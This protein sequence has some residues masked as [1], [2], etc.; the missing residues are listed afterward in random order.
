MRV[1]VREMTQD[2][3]ATMRVM[4]RR[5]WERGDMGMGGRVESGER[6]TEN[7][8]RGIVGYGTVVL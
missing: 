7:G 5:C 8:E 2:M 6:R 1:S 4:K 3:A